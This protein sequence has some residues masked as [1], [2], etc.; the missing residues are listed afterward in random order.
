MNTE[1]QTPVFKLLSM[2]KVFEVPDHL[3]PRTELLEV[4]S[5]Y[6]HRRLLT[7]RDVLEKVDVR[8]SDFKLVVESWNQIKPL[9][10]GLFD[11]ESIFRVQAVAVE[12]RM[13]T[14]V[15][16]FYFCHYLRDDCNKM[17]IGRNPTECIETIR[18]GCRWVEHYS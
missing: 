10:L 11:Y 12:G 18:E 1:P 15:L 14:Q 6:L 16:E 7:I 5:D 2:P 17:S 3:N 9:N 8:M 13:I 4:F